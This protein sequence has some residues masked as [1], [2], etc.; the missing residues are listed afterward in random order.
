AGAAVLASGIAVWFIDPEEAPMAMPV[1][2]L[3]AVAAV[4]LPLWLLRSTGYTLERTQLHIRSGPFSW[5]VPIAE[6]RDITAT[7]N[8]LS[9]PALSRDRLL[10]TYGRH[11]R[12]MISPADKDAVLRELEALRTQLRGAA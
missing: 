6:I 5:V 2:A 11:G 10:I 1:L 3:G 7:R 12:I 4:G 8:P 9:S